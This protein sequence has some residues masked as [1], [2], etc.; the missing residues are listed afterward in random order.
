MGLRLFI[1]IFVVWLRAI[2]QRDG[3]CFVPNASG[4]CMLK[5]TVLREI[6]LLAPAGFSKVTKNLD[7]PRLSEV[8]STWSDSIELKMQSPREF[9]SRPSVEPYRNCP[10]MAFHNTP[11]GRHQ[12]RI[13]QRASIARCHDKSRTALP[14]SHRGAQPIIR[15]SGP[16]KRRPAYQAPQPGFSL[17]DPMEV[18]R[19][20]TTPLPPLPSDPAR[21]NMSRSQQDS[22]HPWSSPEAKHW[23][24]EA[25]RNSSLNHSQPGILP[26]A[27][28]ERGSELKFRHTGKI[29]SVPHVRSVSWAGYDPNAGSNGSHGEQQNLNQGPGSNRQATGSF[30]VLSGTLTAR[31]ASENLPR[32]PAKWNVETSRRLRR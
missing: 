7:Q 1:G 20:S 29:Q 9:A 30:Q 12:T 23:M 8:S 4:Q 31:P 19:Y 26:S 25:A 27:Q 15:H 17:P 16:M 2:W 13:H 18:A 5:T 28:H 14:S 32:Q 3:K 6:Y 24:H 11:W 21:S 10:P 22:K